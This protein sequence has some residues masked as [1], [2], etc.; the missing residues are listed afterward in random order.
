MSNCTM[1]TGR[2]ATRTVKPIP[3]RFAWIKVSLPA[4]PRLP[5]ARHQTL[6]H[7]PLL[8]RPLQ[9]SPPATHPH[10]HL[11]I[12]LRRATPRRPHRLSHPHNLRLAHPRRLSPRAV[13]LHIRLPIHP[14]QVGPRQL[15]RQTHPLKLLPGRP[16]QP[17]R[18][19]THQRSQTLRCGR[20]SR[21]TS[22]ITCLSC[23]ESL[24]T[25]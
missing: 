14:R 24:S 9:P 17:S 12:R 23:Q 19:A 1:S 6:P 18:R 8:A 4:Q 2:P 10:G 20:K 13:H 16:P 21:S 5:P 25:M 7:K 15:R 3:S 22:L 11:P